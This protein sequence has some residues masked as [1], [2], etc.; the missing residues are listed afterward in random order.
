MNEEYDGIEELTPL[1][2]EDAEAASEDESA[3]IDATVAEIDP[4]NVAE[5]AEQIANALEEAEEQTDT[6]DFSASI[7][8]TSSI[9]GRTASKSISGSAASGGCAWSKN[10]DSCSCECKIRNGNIVVALDPGMIPS[11]QVLLTET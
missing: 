5:S 9:N 8:D 10:T 4:D 11:T 6:S 1:D 3:A 7:D 2:A